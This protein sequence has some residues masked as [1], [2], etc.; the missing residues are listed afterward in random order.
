MPRYAR[1]DGR[2]D[3]KSLTLPELEAEMQG[4]GSE[5]FRV[6]GA[7]DVVGVEWAGTLKNTLAIA[8]GALDA[9]GL[10]WNAR[11]MMITRGLA[12]MVRFGIALGAQQGTFLGL[13]GIGD[14]LATCSSPLSRNYRVGAGLAKGQKLDEI[15]KGLGGTAEGVRTTRSV[16]EFAQ[17]R[18]I[19]MPITGGVYQLLRQEA[20]IQEIIRA[21]MTRPPVLDELW[22]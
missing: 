20:P 3:V 16:H 11:S 7:T 17:A 9:L 2:V 8:S 1:D 4:M 10:G 5:K 12:E 13:A 21:L 19:S 14:L 22:K 15:L 6:Y 18:G